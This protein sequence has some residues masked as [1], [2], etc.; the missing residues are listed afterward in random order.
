VPRSAVPPA[1]IVDAWCIRRRASQ[2]GTP[3]GSPWRCS[4][5]ASA[6]V[7]AA[8]GRAVDRALAARRSRT[9][10]DLQRRGDGASLEWLPQETHPV[11]WRARTR[12]MDIALATTQVPSAWDV[13][14]PWCS[15]ADGYLARGGY[16]AAALSE[17]MAASAAA[18]L[19]R[20]HESVRLQTATRR[21]P[22][23]WRVTAGGVPSSCP[24][25]LASLSWRVARP[26]GDR[27]I[28]AGD[29]GRCPTC[30]R[31]PMAAPWPLFA[32]AALCGMPACRRAML[33]RTRLAAAAVVL[34][35]LR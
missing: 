21:A 35:V 6:G 28:A 10:C 17:R 31:S 19:D 8:G 2:A 4:A 12:T 24:T 34:A 1:S 27:H 26:G 30:E 9:L 15:A 5:D 14:K 29:G 7:T 23:S 25:S 20:A 22:H 11:R 13:P 16:T 33:A 18:G 32:T 3:T